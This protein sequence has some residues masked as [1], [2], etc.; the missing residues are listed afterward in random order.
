MVLFG[1]FFKLCQLFI[2]G[3]SSVLAGLWGAGIL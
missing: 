1:E 2:L 3:L